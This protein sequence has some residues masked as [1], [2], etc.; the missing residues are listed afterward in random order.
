MAFPQWSQ[1]VDINCTE[2]NVLIAPIFVS[3]HYVDINQIV[4]G[5]I[6]IPEVSEFSRRN[7]HLRRRLRIAR[8][9]IVK[10]CESRES[11]FVKAE[12]G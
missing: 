10:F 12:K 11:N 4:L 3:E 9:L 5:N 6:G 2:N 1:A 7:E 8:T